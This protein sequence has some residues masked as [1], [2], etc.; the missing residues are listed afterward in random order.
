MLYHRQKVI[1]AHFAAFISVSSV[2][3]VY[4][5]SKDNDRALWQYLLGFHKAL[6]YQSISLYIVFEY[7]FA[8]IKHLAKRKFK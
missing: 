7:E 6:M 2:S 4:H 3:T 1:H 5:V 8:L